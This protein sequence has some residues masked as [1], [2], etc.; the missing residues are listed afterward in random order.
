MCVSYR[1]LNGITKTFDFPILPCDD[2]ISTVV[3][4]SNKISIISLDARQLYYQI[5]V[6]HVDREKLAFFIPYKQ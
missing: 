3:S 4:R 5:S 6:C 2:D 1:K